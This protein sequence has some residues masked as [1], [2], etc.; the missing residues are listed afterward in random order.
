MASQFETSNGPKGGPSEV[1]VAVSGVHL[2]L[3]E[4][5]QEHVDRETRALASKFSH[6]TT[7]A[8]ARFSKGDRG[9]GFTCHV[10]LHAGSHTSH[11][12]QGH[13]DTA[14]TAFSDALEHVAKQL[15]RRKRAEVE[16]RKHRE[17]RKVI[18]AMQAMA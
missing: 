10:H 2:D 15:R 14:Y 7:Q 16:D 3:G 18:E 4:S 13:G 8:E 1:Q 9:I 5:L 17:P 11:D 12:G 6:G